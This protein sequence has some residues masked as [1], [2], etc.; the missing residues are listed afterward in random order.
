MIIEYI[1]NDISKYTLTSGKE[2]VLSNLELDEL[3]S[4]NEIF[5]E[6][7]DDIERFESVEEENIRLEDELHD[8]KIETRELEDSNSRLNLEI[9]ELKEQIE[10]LKEEL[11]DV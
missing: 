10:E 5:N 7:K 6:M 11:R 3:C 1:A 9:D 4:E 2:I 8:L